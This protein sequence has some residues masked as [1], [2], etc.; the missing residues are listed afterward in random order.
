MV[1]AGVWTGV[2]SGVNMT[3]DGEE[4]ELGEVDSMDSWPISFLGVWSGI[5][6][7]VVWGKL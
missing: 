2:S 3:V 4:L 7:A 6:Q 5:V 1:N